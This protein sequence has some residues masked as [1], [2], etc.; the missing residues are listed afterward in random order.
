MDVEQRMKRSDDLYFRGFVDAAIVW[1]LTSREQ[2]PIALTESLTTLR[3]DLP[4]VTEKYSKKAPFRALFESLGKMHREATLD[5]V[6]RVLQVFMPL[7]GSDRTCRDT[8]QY[9]LELAAGMHTMF[10]VGTNKPDAD[11]RVKYLHMLRDV[12]N[13]PANPEVVRKASEYLP[14]V[15]VKVPEGYHCGCCKHAGAQP[16]SPPYER[17]A[18]RA[19]LQDILDTYREESVWS[20]SR[21]RPTAPAAASPSCEKKNSK[22]GHSL[23][24]C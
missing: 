18:L 5:S 16:V 13:E 1:Y 14:Q 23:S 17:E 11:R 15:P 19:E 7:L 12:M 6:V 9:A 8:V 3:V 10:S 21:K 22:T 4:I 20:L 24:S 2:R